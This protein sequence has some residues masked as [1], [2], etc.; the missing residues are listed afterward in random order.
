V[1][2]SPIIST[3]FFSR[4]TVH[5]YLA[6]RG[7]VVRISLFVGLSL[8]VQPHCAQRYLLVQPRT[9]CR[10]PKS[11]QVALVLRSPQ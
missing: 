11:R 5:Y 8:G 6:V 1:G 7:L 9:N 4:Q 2:S 10:L 3:K